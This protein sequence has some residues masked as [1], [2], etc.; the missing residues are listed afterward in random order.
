ME[1]EPVLSSN[2]RS[3]RQLIRIALT[4]PR[5]CPAEQP[6]QPASSPRPATMPEGSVSLIKVRRLLQSGPK[7]R[8]GTPRQG[9]SHRPSGQGDV[10]PYHPNR[11]SGRHRS[12]LA[13]SLQRQT[14][15]WRMVQ[16]HDAGHFSV[17]EAKIPIAPCRR[18][19]LPIWSIRRLSVGIRVTEKTHHT[20]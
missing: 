12:V 11:R 5:C 8:P 1:I 20:S 2:S 10:G 18:L 4:L 15:E 3:V 17:Q 9:N 7:R 16:A 19:L 14:G 6:V 13:Q